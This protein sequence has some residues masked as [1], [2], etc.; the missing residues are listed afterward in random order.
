MQ[1]Y[2]T[3][4]GES[5]GEYG[6]KR[7]SFIAVLS[8]AENEEQ[9]LSFIEKIRTKHWDA[10]HNVFAYSVEGGS[11]KRFSDD[12]EPHGTAGKP[13]M[14][15]L[16]GAGITNAVIVVTRYFGGVLLGTGG[17]V[18]A[19]SAAAREAVASA[20]R[21]IMLP[22]VLYTT[23]CAYNDYGALVNLIKEAGGEIT[24][25]LFEADVTVEYCLKTENAERFL[26]DLSEIFSARVTAN[27]TGGK[28]M[29][30]RI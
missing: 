12:G 24:D 23:V 9:A 5:R 7:S 16:N 17:L 18:R 21:L 1:G 19:Y 14:D 26:K 25:T 30:F 20:Q 8:P 27:E 6:E 11:L 3:V 28:M 4:S 2:I 10:R 22:C 15:I 13:V 29:P